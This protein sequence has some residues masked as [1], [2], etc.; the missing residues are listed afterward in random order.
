MFKKILV[1]V[2]GS[3]G[4]WKALETAK[5]I[6]QKFGANLIVLT[7]VQRFAGAALAPIAVDGNAMNG[8]MNEIAQ[9][10]S[11]AAN[12][13][14]GALATEYVT[15]VGR[16]SKAIVNEAKE[17][18]ADLIVIGSRGLSGFAEFFLG[19]VSSEVAQLCNVPVLIVK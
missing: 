8:Q 4:G 11:D 2:D 5:E 7:V 3:E 15:S 18:G 16:P 13:K 17:K 12:E 19:S 9:G 10:I 6:A 1:P 14:V